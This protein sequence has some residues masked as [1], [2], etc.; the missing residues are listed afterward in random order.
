MNPDLRI[1][2]RSEVVFGAGVSGELPALVRA[3]GVHAAFVVCDRGIARAGIAATL[4]ERLERDGVRV[5]A[6]D[7]VEANPSVAAVQAGTRALRAFGGPAA[8]VALGGGSSLDAAKA[9]ALQADN[10]LPLP[11]LHLR[12]TPAAPARPVLAVP[13]TAGTGSEANAFGVIRDPSRAGKLYVGHPTALP[14]FAV[15]DPALTVTLPAAVTAAC[16]IDVLAHAVESLQARTANP[17]AAAL[18]L[19]AARLVARHLPAAVHDGE[20][21]GA[22]GQMLLAAHLAAL[23]FA[24]T[25][26]GLA[27]AIGHALSDRHGT[28]HGVALAA[29]LPAVA[30]RNRRHRRE[31]TARLAE[32]LGGS[33]ADAVPDAIAALQ[34]RVGMRPGLAELGVGEADLDPLADDALADEVIANAPGEP[35]HAEVLALLR[36]AW[37]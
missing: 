32:A 25:G 15:L 13:T 7:G 23:A 18:A 14:R 5:G 34:D 37:R 11:A 26:L 3:T 30:R 12:A 8:V 4:I 19:E 35:S 27:H 6:Y 28:P 9:M 24:T 20:D 36:A 2:Q 22:R 17:Y 10:D 16:G 29:V 31:V 33:G 21:V 1:A